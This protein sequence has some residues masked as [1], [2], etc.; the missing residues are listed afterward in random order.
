MNRPLRPTLILS[1]LLSLATTMRAEA[2]PVPT[3]RGLVSVDRPVV[4]LKDL[5]SGVGRERNVVLGPAPSPG[6]RYTVG[7]SQLRA[8]ADKYNLD[9]QPGAADQSVTVERA[10]LPVARSDIVTA[11]RPAIQRAGAPAHVALRIGDAHL[12]MVPPDSNP[13]ILVNQITYDAAGGRFR[14]T[15]LV[16][17]RRMT[18]ESTTISGIATP[19]AQAVVAAR[20][21]RPGEILRTTDVRL[22]WVPR[23]LVSHRSIRSLAGIVGMQVH[24]MISGG[25]VVSTRMVAAPTLIDR[26]AAVSLAVEMPGLRVTARG[27]AL[28]AGSLGGIIPVINPTSHE[29]VQAIVDGPDEAHV[30]PGST[31][32]RSHTTVPYY[33]TNGG[34]P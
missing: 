5:F 4:K 34:Q 14:A 28:A 13:R 21:L 33:N 31:P 6:A 18:P 25:S 3:A 17:A 7:A 10:G 22:S 16:T 1:A 12:P 29:V 26:G 9:W 19:A 11:L 32:T 27:V 23:N 2:G 24:Q 8:I 20:T 15:L 30:L